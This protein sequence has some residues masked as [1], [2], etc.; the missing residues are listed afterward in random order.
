MYKSTNNRS[1]LEFFHI[2]TCGTHKNRGLLKYGIPSTYDREC[3]LCPTP[4]DLHYLR[5][6]LT[7]VIDPKYLCIALLGE[8]MQ[9]LFYY[10][11]VRYM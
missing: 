9:L 7:P 4:H 11:L 1:Y 3:T 2:V 10:S 6:F 8:K 5:V